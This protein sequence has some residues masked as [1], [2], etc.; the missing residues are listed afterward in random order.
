MSLHITKE[1]E[2]SHHYSALADKCINAVKRR[3]LRILDRMRKRRG[4]KRFIM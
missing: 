3:D 2:E 1:E 4:R